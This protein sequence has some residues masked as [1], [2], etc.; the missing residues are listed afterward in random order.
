VLICEAILEILERV[1]DTAKG[2][3]RCYTII[4]KLW[5]IMICGFGIFFAMVESHYDINILQCSPVFERIA[6]GNTL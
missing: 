2:Y 6:K 4:L 3:L 5:Q 1:T